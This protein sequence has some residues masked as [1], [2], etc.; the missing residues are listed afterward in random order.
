MGWFWKCHL[1]VLILKYW[2]FFSVAVVTV[3]ASTPKILSVTRSSSKGDSFDMEL[4]S[5]G[6]P[7]C[8]Q[9]GAVP[10]HVQ[11]NVGETSTCSCYCSNETKPT[12]YTTRSGQHGC[13][14]DSDILADTHGGKRR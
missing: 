1:V 3:N 5:Y 4:E 13:V 7:S 10:V 6:C 9:Y 2:S 11:G 8:Q 12:F 14:K